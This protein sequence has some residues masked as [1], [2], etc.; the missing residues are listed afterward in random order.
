MVIGLLLLAS[1]LI[2]TVLVAILYKQFHE[3][4]ADV[5]NLRI[6]SGVA[7]RHGLTAEYLIGLNGQLIR[8]V[9]VVGDDRKYIPVC[10]IKGAWPGHEILADV[11]LEI[12]NLADVTCVYELSHSEIGVLEPNNTDSLDE[13][14]VQ[15]LAD[16]IRRRAKHFHMFFEPIAEK[17]PGRVLVS[18]GVDGEGL[19]D[20]AG[21]KRL[22]ICAA[23]ACHI[24]SRYGV[25]HD[26]ESKGS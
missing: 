9:C 2:I 10:I 26:L 6:A 14:S 24:L 19:K 15:Q 22:I 16:A 12:S 13:Y 20:D 21:W 25:D 23:H 1:S 18:Y 8:K 5:R 3:I 7:A 17:A 11:S 4:S